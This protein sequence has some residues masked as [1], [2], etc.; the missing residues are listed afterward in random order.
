MNPGLK[1]VYPSIAITQTKSLDELFIEIQGVP[2][3]NGR[4]TLSSEARS[5]RTDDMSN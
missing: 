1:H 2:V 5:S 3:P 4:Q